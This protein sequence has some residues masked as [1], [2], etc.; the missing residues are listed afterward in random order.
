M[1]QRLGQ[2]PDGSWTM[3]TMYAKS[4]VDLRVPIRSLSQDTQVRGFG[5]T[6]QCC[7]HLH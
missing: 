4:P 6:L 5:E 7:M 3:L 1:L 2:I